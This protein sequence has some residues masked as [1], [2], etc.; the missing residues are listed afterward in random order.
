ME[1]QGD[2]WIGDAPVDRVEILLDFWGDEEALTVKLRLHSG[3]LRA[4]LRRAAS[5]MLS[6]GDPAGLALSDIHAL[7]DRIAG[8]LQISRSL[9]LRPLPAAQAEK[10]LHADWERA[11]V[12]AAADDLI[13]EKWHV[14]SARAR[15]DVESNL[16]I[17]SY[18]YA[19]LAVITDLKVQSIPFPEAMNGNVQR[20][21]RELRALGMP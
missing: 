5:T 19:L 8:R 12:S 15:E 6:T 4:D 20:L 10:A 17:G 13:R 9:E 16:K 18:S 2:Q 7:V 1:T 14:L 21:K 11:V 3:V